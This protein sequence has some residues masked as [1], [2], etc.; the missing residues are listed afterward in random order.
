MAPAN[1]GRWPIVA[2]ALCSTSALAATTCFNDDD[3]QGRIGIWTYEGPVGRTSP[4]LALGYIPGRGEYRVADLW[5]CFY[6]PKP[7]VRGL[8]NCRSGSLR[9]ARSGLPGILSVEY[10]FILSNGEIK[11]AMYDAGHCSQLGLY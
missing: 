7:K 9:V 4:A 11:T 3:P 8:I 1:F 6:T 10:E 2:I 5:Y